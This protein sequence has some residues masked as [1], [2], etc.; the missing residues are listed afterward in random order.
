MSYYTAFLFDHVRP[1]NAHVTHKF[2]GDLDPVDV[3]PIESLLA[4]YFRNEFLFKGKI[5]TFEFDTIDWFGP[6]KNI[7]VLKAGNF[8]D[9][10]KDLRLALGAYRKD[11]Y[12][13]SPHLTSEVI[14][15]GAKLRPDRYSLVDS[16][17]GEVWRVKFKE[18]WF[19]K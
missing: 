5:Q 3:S 10:F 14:T 8:L 1:T 15:V 17:R 7:R 4:S 19:K 6:N 9:P 2:L 16:K 12:L 18:S 11:N 13:F